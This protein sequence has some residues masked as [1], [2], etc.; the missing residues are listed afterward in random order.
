MND[1][2]H[3]IAE[4]RATARALHRQTEELE[5]RA[6]EYASDIILLIPII[7]IIADSGITGFKRKLVNA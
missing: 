2:D 1:M 4:I 3:G 7:C 6:M 5:R